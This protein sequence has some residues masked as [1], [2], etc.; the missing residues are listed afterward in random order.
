MN[1]GRV[2]IASELL[3]GTVLRASVATAFKEPA[4]EEIFDGPFSQ[5]ARDLRPERS[6]SREAGLEL[7]APGGRVTVGATAFDQRFS[8]LV[9]YQ[10]VDRSIDH[11]TPNFY[12][13]VAAR[14]RGWEFEGR[15]AP[16]GALSLHASYTLLSTEVTNEGNGGFGTIANGFPLLRRPRRSGALDAVYRSRRLVVTGVAH[17]VGAR[18]DYVYGNPNNRARL[19]PYTLVEA[20]AEVP[21]VAARSARGWNV[22]LTGR[23]ENLTNRKYENVY[24]FATP[25][26]VILLGIRLQ[27]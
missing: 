9:Q 2:G 8:D 4:F 14:A 16:N 7:R 21:L 10:D 17:R 15:A 26:R 27:N 22:A 11:T 5:G 18:D 13:I 20:S 24:G 23:A 1:T 19:E 25:G 6:R 12:N 3:P